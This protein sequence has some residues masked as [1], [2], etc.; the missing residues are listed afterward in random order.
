MGAKSRTEEE[1]QKWLS[2][3]EDISRSSYLY[4]GYISVRL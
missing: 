1:I 3:I 2:N 4:Q